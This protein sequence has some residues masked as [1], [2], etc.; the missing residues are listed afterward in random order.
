[1]KGENH[2][3]ASIG[4]ATANL[5][6]GDLRRPGLTGLLGMKG[7]NGLSNLISSSEDIVDLADQ[8]ELFASELFAAAATLLDALEAHNAQI[9]TL[10][11]LENQK[12]TGG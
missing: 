1:M 10:R 7:M 4:G 5:Q 9:T 8:Y 2:G 12:N 6:S 11:D 3:P